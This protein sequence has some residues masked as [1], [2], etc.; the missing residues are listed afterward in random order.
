MACLI[1]TPSNGAKGVVTLTTQE[2]DKLVYAFP[3][4]RNQ[5]LALKD[6]YLIGLHHNW[7]DTAL[8]YD[9]LF[10]FHLAGAEDLVEVNG[11]EIPLIPMDACNFSPSCFYPQDGEKFWDILFVARAVEFKGIPEFFKAIRRLYDQGKFL[12]V[13]F[14]CPI[15][16][17][18]GAGILKNVR[19]LYEDLF[20]VK[21]Q[22]T[23]TLLTAD[24]RYPFPFDLP[25]LAYFYRASKIF[26]HSAPDERRCRV[27][28]Y[29][30]STNMPVVG[31][32][33]IGSVL[34]KGLRQPPYF[35]ETSTYD[36]FPQKILEAIDGLSEKSNFT[37]I[38]R[39]ISSSES[40]KLF[41]IHLNRI[42]KDKKLMPPIPG[43][44]MSDL[45]IRLGRHHGI[46]AGVNSIQQDISE[47]LEFLNLP[48][49]R[50]VYELKGATN[51]EECI[52]KSRPTNPRSLIAEEGPSAAQLIRQSFIKSM[53]RM[54]LLRPGQRFGAAYPH[55]NELIMGLKNGKYFLRGVIGSGNISKIRWLGNCSKVFLI[56]RINKVYPC[57]FLNIGAGT[58]SEMIGWWTDEYQSGFIID[59]DTKLPFKDETIEFAYSSMFFEHINDETAENLFKEIFR[60][61]RPGGKARIV[62]PDFELYLDEY[63][64]GNLNFFYNQ[65]DKIFDLGFNGRT[66][67]HGA[68]IGGHDFIDT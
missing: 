49:D 4:I 7:H 25:T 9:P 53:R 10:D 57:K 48:T 24:Y 41:E 66:V 37:E 62:V 64:K 35:Y 27:A 14:I 47:F 42:Y 68:F 55:I 3:D 22:D 8:K 30:W 60:V 58:N 43:G 19:Q 39:E 54:K 52:F 50:M 65:D 32:E 31:M 44:W 26:V 56:N 34:S 15:P 18:P 12:R 67:G 36:D 17:D 29:A 59:K 33:A 63:H 13:L 11:L 38:R 46:P 20:S 45:D 28:A 61:L 23:F 16:P 1:K 6:R 5:V 2:R 40:V 51:P 21:E